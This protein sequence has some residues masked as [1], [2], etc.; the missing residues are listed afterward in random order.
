MTKN[1]DIDKYGYSGYE[2]AFDRKGEFS[3]SGGGYGQNVLIFGVD[4]SSSIHIDK[5]TVILVLGW[6]PTQGLE[7]TLTAEKIYSIN[8][9]E[10]DK[11]FC[12]SLHFNGAN[13]YLYVNGTEIYKFKAKDS[14]IR[15][16]PLCLGN[17]SKDWSTNNVKKTG[18]KEYIYDFSVDYHATDVDDIKDIHK[19]LMKKNNI[20]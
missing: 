20:I 5:K 7:H 12:L 11:K 2:I 10:K 15:A 19:Y 18:F 8:F 9:T 6:G 16:S 17:I 14:E 4:M 3:F 13:S 1:T